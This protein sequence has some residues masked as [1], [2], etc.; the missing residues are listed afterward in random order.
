VPVGF[1][2]NVPQTTRHRGREA[3]HSLE[4]DL[5]LETLLILDLNQGPGGYQSSAA[6]NHVVR[7]G[8]VELEDRRPNN[9]VHTKLQ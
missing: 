9:G 5:L 8:T 7:H 6:K 1:N 4:Q 3:V 2:N